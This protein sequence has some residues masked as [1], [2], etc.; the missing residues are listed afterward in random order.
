MNT[1]PLSLAW[2]VVLGACAWPAYGQSVPAAASPKGEKR[3]PISMTVLPPLTAVK[4]KMET[5][6]KG[7]EVPW[8]IAFT[9]PDRMLFT[10]R[11]GRVRQVRKGV[12]VN[13][14]LAVIEGVVH[15]GGE[16]GLMGMC[17]DPDYSENKFIYLAYGYSKLENGNDS[18]IRVVRYT[19]TGNALENA[20]VIIKGFPSGS[21]HAGCRV[22][23]G[24]DKKLY[25]TTGE[26][27]KRALAQDMT[28]LGG[29][30]LRINADGTIPSDNPFVG[31]EVKA[32][33][34]RPEIWSFGHRNPQGLDWQPGTGEL[35][36]SE[37]GPSGSDAPGGGDEFNHVIKGHNFGWPLVHHAETNDTS[38]APLVE[39]TPAIAPSSGTFYTGSLFPELKGVFLITCLRGNGLIAITP[40]GDTIEK[41]ETLVKGLGRLRAATVGPD[42]AIYFATS[43]RDGRGRGADEDDR[44]I[45]LV[46]ET[47]AK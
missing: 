38:D 12:L 44:I 25:I 6:V 33:G 32:K 5:V 4:F 13:E 11:A 41:Q 40:K 42:G 26:R 30:I 34:T 22:R 31:A 16:N 8:D 15:I 43:N 17:L 2:L 39:F 7:A 3:V 27:Y 9:S 1:A 36:S 18:D 24:P 45:R 10:E 29:K 14:P 21:N 47:Q 28:S 37:H 46:P 23:F 20:T 35:Y 19:D